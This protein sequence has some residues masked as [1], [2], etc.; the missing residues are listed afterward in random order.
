MESLFA[1]FPKDDSTLLAFIVLLP[2]IGAFVNGVF[3]KRLGREAVTLMGLAVIFGSFVLSVAAFFML[4]ELQ[5]GEEAV[6]A[7]RLAWKGWDWVSLSLSGAGGG[8]TRISVGL[9]IDAL[10]GTMALVVTGVG[11]LIHLYSSKYME[12]DPGYHRF[13][14][15]LNLFIFSMLVLI[16]GDSL[17]V[18]FVGWEGVGLCSYLLIGFWFEDEANATAGKKAF[19]T[20]RIGDFGLLVGMGLLLYYTGA[21]D[22]QGIENGRENLFRAISL[23]PDHIGGVSLKSV[24]V[25]GEALPFQVSAATLVGL[26]LFLGCAGKSAQIPLYVWLPDAMAG[27]TPVSAL[28]H[29]AT[30]VTAGIY[31]VCRLSMVF[32]LS[33]AAMLTIAI[34]GGATALLA[35]TIAF[36]QN[37]IKKVLAYSTV[38]QL[39]YMFLGV[40]VGAFT[41]GFF[42]VITHA[43]FK[44]CLFL[45]AGSVIHAMHA[46][47]HDSAK[48]QDMRNMGGLRP[49]LPHTF[50]TFLAA[51]AAIIGI[52]LTS[53]FFSKDAI[54]VAAHTSKIELA[55]ENIT[56]KNMSTVD[57]FA[58]P[59][60]AGT[61]L[62][63]MGVA[64]A[65]MTAFYMTRLFIGIFFGDFKG[66][67]IVKRWKD[68]G[69][70]HDHHHHDDKP[71]E[72]PV[73]HES[74]LQMTVPLMI[75][76]GLSLVAG[77]L[78]AH[79]FVHDFDHWLAPVF[80]TASSLVKTGEEHSLAPYI[81][82]AV[83]ACVAGAGG[84]WWVYV[85]QK[86]APAHAFVTSFPRLYELVRDKWRVDEFYE[87]TFIGAVD[88][89]AVAATW[90]D[91]WIV[92]GIFARLSAFVV[93][94]FGTLLRYL[95]AGR[96]QVYALAMVVGLGAFG[97]YFLVPRAE[98]KVKPNVTTGA[99]SITAAPGLGYSYRWDENADG[100]WESEK[101]GSKNE[102]SLELK[103]AETRKVRL[104]VQNAFGNTATR[105]I[106]VERPKVYKGGATDD[107]QAAIDSAKGKPSRPPP[108]PS[109]GRPMPH[110]VHP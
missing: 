101:F 99:Y 7:G 106:T 16:L 12:E 69:H 63:A 6:Q 55:R 71:L 59:E 49:Y 46:R 25:I 79:P 86:G 3:G 77:F 109:A 104:E 21:L 44:A 97:F 84:A 80:K 107:E 43:F 83:A 54:L 39:G 92:D 62:Y 28:I 41:A 53:G 42:H 10:S 78:N 27:P 96:V 81:G 94:V 75:L 37:D 100:K 64:G 57:L 8:E 23:F 61:L 108:G 56:G 38:S 5:S 67:T 73:P 20:N 1:L 52:P 58:W 85:A 90:F 30:M 29:A 98:A 68:P 88:T 50:L 13:F 32:V 9:S 103:P 47:I 36:A 34:A 72:G 65:V 60:W 14:A 35:A 48:S 45:G 19:I 2:L 87:E 93:A 51:W 18:L 15:Y 76:G 33:P 89:L 26:A 17:P 70:G 40:G 95:Q 82:V 31:L 102:L 4:R 66:W 11:F 105:L 22:W 91:K 24:P 110:G 74:P